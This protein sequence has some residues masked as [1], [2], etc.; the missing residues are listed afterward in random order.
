MAPPTIAAIAPS[1]ASALWRAAPRPENPSAPPA[2]T[3]PIQR[4]FY[5]AS[6][7]STISGGPGTDLVYLPGSPSDWVADGQGSYVNRLNPTL[8][9]LLQDVEVVRF[10]SADPPDA[11]RSVLD[12]QA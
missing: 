4:V 12:A 2:E 7:S 5:A 1:P 3:S 10:Y 6:V 8:R 9:V 11:T